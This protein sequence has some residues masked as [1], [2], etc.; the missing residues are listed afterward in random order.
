ME[1]PVQVRKPNM[2]INID[3]FQEHARKK[4]FIESQEIYNR[5]LESFF[6]GLDL[7]FQSSKE[8]TTKPFLNKQKIKF[9][10][11]S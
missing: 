1:N 8:A 9:L 5:N 4:I 2:L 6:K 11:L 10:K 7:S 3:I